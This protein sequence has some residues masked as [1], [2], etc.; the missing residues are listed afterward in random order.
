MPE[1]WIDS[2]IYKNLASLPG[3][4][5]QRIRKAISSL[6]D[7]PRPHNAK[8]LEVQDIEVEVWRIRINQWRIIYT[9]DSVADFISVW[10]IRKRPPYDYNDLSDLLASIQTD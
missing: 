8:Q 2:P 10:A 4:I 7:N 9:I 6:A 1:V 5:R 3:N